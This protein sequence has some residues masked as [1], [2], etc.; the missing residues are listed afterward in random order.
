MSDERVEYDFFTRGE[1][2]RE[3]LLTHTWCD[4]CQQADL[5]MTHPVEYEHQGLRFVEGRCRACAEIVFTELSDD[6]F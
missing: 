3:A 6:E 1:D 2:E 5:G 4:H